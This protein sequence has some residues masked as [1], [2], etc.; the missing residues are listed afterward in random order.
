MSMVDVITKSPL[1]T[2]KMYDDVMRVA[3]DARLIL[4]SYTPSCMRPPDQYEDAIVSRVQNSP[5]TFVISLLLGLQ[6]YYFTQSPAYAIAAFVASSGLTPFILAPFTDIADLIP[7]TRAELEKNLESNQAKLAELD[8]Q[9]VK[10][11]E[12]VLD[13]Y[14]EARYTVPEL[15]ARVEQLIKEVHQTLAVGKKLRPWWF[16]YLAYRRATF[17]MAEEEKVWRARHDELRER[18]QKNDA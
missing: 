3:W 5:K 17:E 11:M 15:R 9:F 12:D 16:R 8:Q 2:Y 18:I 10:L 6:T 4:R 13:G 14:A 7:E 1:Y